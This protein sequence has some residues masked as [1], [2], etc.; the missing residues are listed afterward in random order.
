MIN[1]NYLDNNFV[2]ISQPFLFLYSY[3]KSVPLYGP[4]PYSVLEYGDHV[5]PKL[6]RTEL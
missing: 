5:D 3:R 2:S 1:R 4:L 6:G